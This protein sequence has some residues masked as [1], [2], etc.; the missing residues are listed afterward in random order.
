MKPDQ[1]GWPLRK[2]RNE[3]MNKTRD[4]GRQLAAALQQVQ[5]GRTSTPRSVRSWTHNATR[6][7]STKLHTHEGRAEVGTYVADVFRQ[8]GRKGKA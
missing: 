7:S 4:A 5:D 2:V 3:R 1:Q 6:P 8:P